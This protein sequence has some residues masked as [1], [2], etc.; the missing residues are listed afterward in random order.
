MQTSYRFE[1]HRSAMT[2]CPLTLDCFL[3]IWQPSKPLTPWHLP[4]FSLLYRGPFHHL[5]DN[6]LSVFNTNKSMYFNT[7]L[8]KNVEISLVSWLAG[9]TSLF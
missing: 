2:K 1:S 9:N 5:K 8:V 6:G 3:R 7:N 4:L